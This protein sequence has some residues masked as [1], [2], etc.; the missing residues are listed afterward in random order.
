[1]GIFLCKDGARRYEFYGIKRKWVEYVRGRMLTGTTFCL[2]SCNCLLEN[3]EL[4]CLRL[5]LHHKSLFFVLLFAS[6]LSVCAN[7]YCTIPLHYRSIFY[8]VFLAGL[9]HSYAYILTMPTQPRLFTTDLKFDDFFE[10]NP[11]TR[12]CG[13]PFKLY[14]INCTHSS[15]AG[16]FLQCVIN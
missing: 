11:A 6:S 5:T 8:E 10:C 16:I 1:M 15:R 3:K 14:K 9:F 2:L 7:H 4:C 13:H 12:T